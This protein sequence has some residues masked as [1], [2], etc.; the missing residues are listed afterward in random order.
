MRADIA[1]SLI[2][3]PKVLYLDE[4]TIGLDVSA[5]LAMRQAIK[6]MN[7]TFKTTLILTT[8]D[9]DDIEDLCSRI[10]IL[11]HGKIIYDGDLSKIKEK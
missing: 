11:D 7:E 10:M 6:K 3:N 1:A 5:K 4:P 8:H 2:H 9:M